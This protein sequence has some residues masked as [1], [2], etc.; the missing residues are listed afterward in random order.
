MKV[1]ALL[2]QIIEARVTNTLD[3]VMCEFNILKTAGEL[4]NFI[5]KQMVS[6]QETF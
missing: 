6:T 1:K 5:L 4:L 3:I 2:E